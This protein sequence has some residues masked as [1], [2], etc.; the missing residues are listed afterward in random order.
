MRNLA[1]AAELIR[2][3][4]LCMRRSPW[5]PSLDIAQATGYFIMRG[6]G[7]KALH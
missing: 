1:S 6:V 5:V 7:Y 3:D 4:S 2:A